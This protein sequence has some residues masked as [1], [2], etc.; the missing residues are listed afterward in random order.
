MV[1]TSSP[2]WC[3]GAARC[4]R[5]AAPRGLPRGGMRPKGRPGI[6][7]ACPHWGW[8]HGFGWCRVVSGK[9]GVAC[10]AV[11]A[12][13]PG[14][15]WE[16][17]HVE[18]SRRSTWATKRSLLLFS[19]RPAVQASVGDGDRRRVRVGADVERVP[20]ALDESVVDRWR[21]AVGGQVLGEER[22]DVLPPLPGL[23][24]GAGGGQQRVVDAAVLV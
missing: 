16:V 11:P 14:G 20:V 21:L 15:C 8:W 4:G 22:D 7:F 17:H 5:S 12:G 10:G 6:G 19:F 3:R 9:P 1:S 18:I 13:G 23:A 2:R 24:V